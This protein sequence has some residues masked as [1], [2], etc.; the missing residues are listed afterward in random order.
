[1]SAYTLYYYIPFPESQYWLDQTLL[2]RNQYV[3]PTE[4]AGCFV[5][6]DIVD[7]KNGL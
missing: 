1:M 5:D 2:V 6:K 3:I 7:N 4:E